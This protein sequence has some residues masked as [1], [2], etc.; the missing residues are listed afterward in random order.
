MLSFLFIFSSAELA[1]LEVNDH[2]FHISRC[3]INY[4]T[5][6]GDIQIAAH[7]FIDDL[8]NAI[9]TQTK[10]NLHI[11]TPSESKDSDQAIEKYLQ[12]KLLIKSGGKVLSIV[13]LGK[14]TSND[15]LAIWCYLEATGWKNIPEIQ[16]ENKI[17]LE[18]FDDQKNIVDL[19]IN[20]K[21]KHFTIFDDKKVVETYSLP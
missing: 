19:T 8:E 18:I 20:K 11:A 5:N 14:E 16:V 10:K 4:E 17:L 9:T 3:E 2:E 1:Q 21:K 7:I 12:Q 15:K 6:T 13:M